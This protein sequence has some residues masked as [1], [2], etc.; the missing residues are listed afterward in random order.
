MPEPVVVV[1]ATPED[2]AVKVLEKAGFQDGAASV[3]DDSQPLPPAGPQPGV[4]PPV[5]TP[6]P[7]DEIKRLQGEVEELKGLKE[8][9]GWADREKERA[10][11]ERQRANSLE[12]ELRRARA[13]LGTPLK[14]EEKVLTP[15][16]EAGKKWF[17]THLKDMLP[18]ILAEV[19]EETLAKHPAFQKR[20]I[21]IF[22]T[23]EE[24]DQTRFLSQF[25]PEQ[26]DVVQRRILPNL[27]SARQSSGYTKG[28]AEL[29][30]DQKKAFKEAA[31]LYGFA[32][33]APQTPG[34]QPTPV[35]PP[36]PITI[37]PTLSG[38]PSGVSPTGAKSMPMLSEQ[39]QRL[40][41]LR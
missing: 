16:E 35:P 37:P 31:E 30:D 7:Q 28:Y 27:Q 15:E 18:E 10:D 8:R 13:A 29:W 3:P 26:R 2:D 39:D 24:L 14:T 36:A 25:S 38:V 21:A 4:T 20:D 19:P 32:V 33:A 17:R 22:R 12:E 34:P 11:N 6:E 40:M 41:G 5:P 23:R 9:A 1:P